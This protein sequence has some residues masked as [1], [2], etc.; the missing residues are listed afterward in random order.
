M[1][2]VVTKEKGVFQFDKVRPGKYD[3]YTKNEDGTITYTMYMYRDEWAQTSLFA[4]PKEFINV[5]GDQVKRHLIFG[6][7]LIKLEDLTITTNIPEF[8]MSVEFLPRYL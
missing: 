1:R 2:E 5:F 4:S 6:A 3:I 8:D 7:N